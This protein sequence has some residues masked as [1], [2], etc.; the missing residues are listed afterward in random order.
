MLPGGAICSA[1]RALLS[2]FAWTGWYRPTRC[3]AGEGSLDRPHAKQPQ[4]G[5]KVE[6]QSSASGYTSPCRPRAGQS[7]NT[8]SYGPSPTVRRTIT[9]DPPRPCARCTKT[10]T[11]ARMDRRLR[12]AY[13][14]APHEAEPSKAQTE[15]AESGGFRQSI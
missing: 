4:H 5:P 12:L 10:K 3:G 6:L 11:A 8:L 14:P 7:R 2:G 1:N 13:P 15:P 9:F